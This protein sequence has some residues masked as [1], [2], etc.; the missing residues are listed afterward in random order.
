MPRVRSSD[1][2]TGNLNA[3]ANDMKETP[4]ITLVTAALLFASTLF[5]PGA[6]GL[7][8]QESPYK[9]PIPTKSVPVCGTFFF[10]QRLQTKTFA[11]EPPF[12]YNPFRELE[13]PV[14]GLDTTNNIYLVDD[15]SVDWEKWQAEAEAKALEEALSAW[16]AEGDGPMGPL[17]FGPEDLWLEIMALTNEFADLTLHNTVTNQPYALLTKADLTWSNWTAELQVRGAEGDAT[18][19]QLAT[20]KRTNL[21]IWARTCTSSNLTVDDSPTAHQLAQRL[22]GSCVTISS[23]TYTGAAVARGTFTNGIC[24]GL[25]I[26]E[27]VILA[28]GD[29]T[30]A[31]GPN[32]SDMATTPF[33]L[34]GDADLDPLVGGSGTVDAAV[35]E[36][37]IVSSN[38]IVLQFEFA[39]ASEEYPEWIGEYND[40]MAIFVS[41]NYNGTN[42]INAPSNNIAIV[43]GTTN[44]PVSVNT[45]N[46]TTNAQYYVDNGDPVFTTNAPVANI[47]YDGMTVLLTAQIQISSNTTNHIKIA[48][49]DFGD[50]AYDSAVF[51][52]AAVQCP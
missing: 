18:P 31:I 43:P 19:A 41:T 45:I 25:P 50:N 33:G 32:N 21:F 44:L 9:D 51:I 29:I 8:A 39:F 27:G 36:F 35:L 17:D 22:V 34:A 28:S 30:N 48:I 47:Q 26:D 15:R 49:A 6:G 37:D 40:P 12:P 11:H 23:V 20:R 14:Y 13:L 7:A 42:W 2:R 5:G 3:K 16:P 24:S 10:W 46:A 38:S 1:A 4:G 52:K